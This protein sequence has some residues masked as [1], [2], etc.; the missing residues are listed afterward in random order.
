MNTDDKII[1]H[2]FSKDFK[3]LIRCE[4]TYDNDEI[5]IE[6]FDDRGYSIEIKNK[7][8]SFNSDFDFNSDFSNILT[9]F[10]D[11]Y[12]NQSPSSFYENKKNFVFLNKDITY[13]K[14]CD[15][16]RGHINTFSCNKNIN[17]NIF[18]KDEEIKLCY[19]SIIDSNYDESNYDSIIFF[20][21]NYYDIFKK[22]LNINDN[23][24]KKI[25]HN[26]VNN[27][28]FFQSNGLY[29]KIKSNLKTDILSKILFELIIEYPE[30]YKKYYDTFINDITIINGN[31]IYNHFLPIDNNEKNKNW[32]KII[33]N[34]NI[35]NYREIKN[36][37]DIKK[38]IVNILNIYN[39]IHNINNY[40][41]DYENKLYLQ[42]REGLIESVL[43]CDQYIPYI[44][45][46][47]FRDC[48]IGSENLL[49]KIINNCKNDKIFNQYIDL[50]FVDNLTDNYYDTLINY[51]YCKNNSVFDI[52]IINYFSNKSNVTNILSKYTKLKQIDMRSGNNLNDKSNNEICVSLM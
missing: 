14:I 19:N 4:L 41:I 11:P 22:L 50:F 30:I 37:N 51:V 13:S 43:Y 7:L 3:K 8:F 52:K 47:V 23:Y 18:K 15:F 34:E 9:K 28:K 10:F 12:S 29:N 6:S 32:N 24:A 21:E 16:Y 25:I 1:V 33:K 5:K 48:L 39:N 45:I 38:Y 26:L 17:K 35:K 36:E 44:L 40:S 49:L 46:N 27:Y 42:I 20:V 31:M 2:C